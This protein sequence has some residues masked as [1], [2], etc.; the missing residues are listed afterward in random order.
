MKIDRA[1]EKWPGNQFTR[2]IVQHMLASEEP[3]IE[4]RTKFRKGSM[5]TGSMTVCFKKLRYP[6]VS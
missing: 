3:S 5:D 4:V 6:I 2:G 1:R